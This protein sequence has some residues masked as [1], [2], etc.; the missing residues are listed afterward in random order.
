[1]SI[2]AMNRGRGMSEH[3]VS[4]F[5]RNFTGNIGTSGAFKNTDVRRRNAPN[6]GAHA[7]ANT[8]WGNIAIQAMMKGG[9]TA[10]NHPRTLASGI[11]MG[12]A[13]PA[14]MSTQWNAAL[15]P[16]YTDYQFNMRSPD[17]AASDIYIG[18]PGRPPEQGIEI[19]I[20]PLLRW[21]KVA[22]EGIYASSTGLLD[23]SHFRPEN[24]EMREAM[25]SWAQ[26]RYGPSIKEG[27][28]W[29]SVFE[30]SILPPVAP[31]L[32]IPAAAGGADLRSY[33]DWRNINDEHKGGFVA[34]EGK[35]PHATVIGEEMP[36]QA[37]A[38]MRA[39]GASA[40]GTI[41]QVITGTEQRITGSGGQ[42]PAQHPWDAFTSEYWK[43][44]K[45]RIADSTKSLA[46]G[47]LY[48]TFLAIS[49]NTEA[50]ATLVKR[51]LDGMRQLTEAMNASTLPG[52]APRDGLLGNKRLGYFESIGVGPVR[53]DEDARLLGALAKQKYQELS[54]MYLQQL[55]IE[56]EELN[57]IRNST[58]YS[59][60]MK[61]ALMNEKA[62]DIIQFN[63][64][65]LQ[66]IQRYEKIISQQTGMNVR[67]DKVKIG[68]PGAM[69]Q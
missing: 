56:N 50:A 10:I 59:P 46:S 43:G 62:F 42:E 53:G 63:R 51:K 15:G 20:D 30:Q 2:M 40:F 19:S 54:K 41:Y 57:R 55:N 6:W 69:R 34:G 39:L 26:H 31:L 66:D 33:I 24:S 68:A 58:R 18:I 21:A 32:K 29:R 25:R 36:A 1:M 48:S 17:R 28:V 65:M 23:G 14:M 27:S 7:V 64:D 67:F 13:M 61:R 4:D 45:Q 49:P 3:Q 44:G 5:A 37:E 16:E 38:F 22:A 11:F 47:P 8:P 12:T 35:N 60:E 9:K 52:G